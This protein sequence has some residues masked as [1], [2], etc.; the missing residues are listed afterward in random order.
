MTDADALLRFEQAVLPHLDAAHNLA[1]W[2]LRD[3]HDAEDIVQH[4]CLRAFRAFAAFRGEDARGWLLTIVRNSCF[5][6][7]RRRGQHPMRE[8]VGDDTPAPPGDRDGDPAAAMLRRLD[9]E[10]LAAAI[11]ELPALFRETFVLREMEQ[12]SYQQIAD[13]TGVPIGTVMSR[14]ARARHRLQQ[15]L[16]GKVSA[17]E[18][19]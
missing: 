4:A 5:T 2:L 3:R 18:E 17:S 19:R 14:L 11:E 6:E 8:I 10:A 12:L 7:L 16:T 1:R 15:A 9:R 13:V